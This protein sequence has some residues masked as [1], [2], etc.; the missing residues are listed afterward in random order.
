MRSVG[1]CCSRVDGTGPWQS[2]IA[3]PRVATTVTHRLG[4]AAMTV[5]AN[6]VV[7]EKRVSHGSNIVK[8]MSPSS[9]LGGGTTIRRP[10]VLIGDQ[11]RRPKIGER[12]CSQS[13]L[14][15]ETKECGS[16]IETMSARRST[17]SA[18]SR[19]DFRFSVRWQ[20]RVVVALHFFRSAP[21]GPRVCLMITIHQSLL[22]DVGVD[23]SCR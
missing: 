2:R 7:L 15:R 9:S 17:V 21:S 10:A 23:L 3:R 1:C 5:R 16:P 12:S 19:L 13:P 11:F 8:N 6:D 22:R 4:V 20:S 18:A 14:N